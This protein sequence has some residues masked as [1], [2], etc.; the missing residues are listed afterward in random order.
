MPHVS[1]EGPG[2]LI[3]T[4]IRRA[5]RTWADRI[6]VVEL[7]SGA[8]TTYAGLEHQV[9][10][11][12]RALQE[13]LG[14]GTA[15]DA[16]AK[17]VIAI[18]PH[19]PEGVATLAGVLACGAVGGVA[20]VG[21]SAHPGALW[22]RQLAAAGARWVLH[23]DG[24]VNPLAAGVDGR[25]TAAA[26]YQVVATSGSTGVP[27]LVQLTDHGTL[28]ATDVYRQRLHLRT[29]ETVAVP[30]SLASVGALPSGILPALLDGGTAILA[31]GV[32]IGTFIRGLTEHDAVFAMAVTGWW[33]ACLRSTALPA[34]PRLRLL[35][36][37]GSPWQ[38]LVPAIRAWLPTVV[39]VGNYGLTETHG[40]ALQVT[41]VETSRFAEVT[42]RSVGGVEA[43]VRDIS[44]RVVPTGEPGLLWLRGDLVTPGY[45]LASDIDADTD[46]TQPDDDGWLCTGDMATADSDGWIRVSGRV[47]D[48]VNVGGRQVYPAEVESALHAH[49]D[50]ADCAVVASDGPPSDRHLDAFVVTSSGSVLDP[51][52]VRTWVAEQVGGH[53]VPRF[54]ELMI[55]LPV[56]SNGKVDRV[57]LRQ[58]RGTS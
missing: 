9:T 35:G 5:C 23:V 33:Q 36:V 46:L 45:L 22:R 31:G 26:T 58:P 34:L 48:L 57:A 29:G 37:G 10:S 3:T 40:P 44:N 56:T 16:T 27:K 42:G 11:R 54:V 15:H 53:A 25:P 18:T 41:S 17:P 24:T 20:I 38:H 6:A 13:A 19:G 8:A 14:P 49:P 4:A 55:G 21:N 52:A 51:A 50:I 32:G 43:E 1:T 7:A 39:V 30:Q 47:D 28:I 12:I 2:S